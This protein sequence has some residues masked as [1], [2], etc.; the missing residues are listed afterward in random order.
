MAFVVFA[1][2]KCGHKVCISDKDT[3]AIPLKMLEEMTSLECFNCGKS[4]EGN[5]SLLSKTESFPQEEEN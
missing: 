5:W 4:G 1:C 3:G 2:K